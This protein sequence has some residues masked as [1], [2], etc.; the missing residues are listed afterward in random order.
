MRARQDTSRRRLLGT[1][2]VAAIGVGAVG[3]S[4]ALAASD[5][6]AGSLEGMELT[7]YSGRGEGLVQGVIDAFEEKTGA[8]VLVRYGSSAEIGAAILE[9]GDRTPADVFYSQEVGAVGML[10]RAGLLTELPAEVIEHVEER[11][12]PPAG[13]QWVG[14]TGRSRVIVYNPDLVPEPPSGVLE[15][16]DPKWAGQV[17]IVPGNAGFQAFVTGFRVTQGED[18]AREWLEAMIANDVRTDISSNGNVLAAVNDGELALGLINHYYW[19]GLA[20]ELGGAE[21]MTAQ[22]IF[23]T[24]G[25]PGGLFN[26]TAVGITVNG[27]DNPVALAFVEYLLSD[28]GQ[29]YFV[30]QTHEYPVVPGLPGPEGYP[31]RDELD[32]PA[33]D[34]TD[35]DSLDVTQALLTDLGLL[36]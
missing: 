3:G 1:M 17:A 7:L 33:I 32:G 28:E 18:A 10:A 2:V 35:L 8:R 25:D 12:R 20:E 11:F 30:E 23:P 5:D 19:A 31:A 24:G 4:A 21:N 26:A 6:E 14:V 36:S 15:L 29:T 34:L 27:A 9:E 22:L 13:N 16:T